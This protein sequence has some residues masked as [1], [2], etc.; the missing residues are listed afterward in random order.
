M[1]A[2]ERDPFLSPAEDT[3]VFDELFKF[4]PHLMVLNLAL[5][6]SLWAL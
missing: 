2:K 5:Y 3:A 6:T 4:N 1:T